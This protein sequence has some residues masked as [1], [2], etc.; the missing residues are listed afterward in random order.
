MVEPA[1]DGRWELSPEEQA[2]WR[3]FDEL[4]GS[5]AA[6]GELMAEFARLQLRADVAPPAPPPGPPP[7]WMAKRP[8]G[9]R[10]LT[11]AF[12]DGAID[13][14]RLRASDFTAL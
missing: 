5:D 6:D 13:P 2:L 14:E 3:R 9:I 4:S 8:A 1:W 11:A 10:A 12:R 7:P